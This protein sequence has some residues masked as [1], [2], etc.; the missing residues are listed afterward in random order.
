MGHK[1]GNIMEMKILNC[2]DYNNTKGVTMSRNTRKQTHKGKMTHATNKYRKIKTC[3]ERR[4]LKQHLQK[5]KH[6]K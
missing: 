1:K 5:Q 4:K 6:Q 3:Y 2:H